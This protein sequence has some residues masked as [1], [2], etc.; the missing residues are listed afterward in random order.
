M[1]KK[2]NRYRVSSSTPFSSSSSGGMYVCMYVC[3]YVCSF[4]FLHPLH[5]DDCD[6]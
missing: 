6:E 1:K 2:N 5:A 3:T 4:A